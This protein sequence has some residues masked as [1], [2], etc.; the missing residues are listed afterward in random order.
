MVALAVGDNWHCLVTN[1]SWLVASLYQYEAEYEELYVTCLEKQ[2]T[3]TK[4]KNSEM[5]EQLSLSCQRGTDEC[6]EDDFEC[7]RDFVL[8]DQESGVIDLCPNRPFA[9]VV[10]SDGANWGVAADVYADSVAETSR[11]IAVCE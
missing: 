10:I 7:I 11:C 1:K 6:G 4:W 8:D 5:N 3:G 2:S 9:L